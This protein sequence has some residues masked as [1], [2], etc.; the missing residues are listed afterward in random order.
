VRSLA[1]FLRGDVALTIGIA[2]G[3]L[4][5]AASLLGF[6]PDTFEFCAET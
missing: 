2:L 3:L 6:E 4:L 5:C 1:G